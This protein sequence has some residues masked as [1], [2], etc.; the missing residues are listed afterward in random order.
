[1][2]L[3]ERSLYGQLFSITV[4]FAR[5][6]RREYPTYFFP[7]LQLTEKNTWIYMEET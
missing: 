1:M 4:L 5:H 2:A 7:L 6:P 3:I